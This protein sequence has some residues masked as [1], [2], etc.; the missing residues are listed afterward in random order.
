VTGEQ[1][2]SYLLEKE[3]ARKEVVT[4]EQ[5]HSYLLEKEDAR[6]EVVTGEQML[7]YL[8]EK[9]D[10]R[11][12]VVTGEQML[13]YLL[14]KED[15]R[16]EVVTGQEMLS[17]MLEKEPVVSGE[18]MLSYFL[19]VPSASPMPSPRSS[20]GL[21]T[22]FDLLEHL[23]FS[24]TTKEQMFVELVLSQLDKK[25]SG[26]DL[27]EALQS[28]NL[29][30]AGQKARLEEHLHKKNFQISGE[31]LYLYLQQNER[32]S[33]QGTGV[34][35]GIDTDS[36]DSFNGVV[37]LWDATPVDIDDCLS[38]MSKCD[39]EAGAE[40]LRAVTHSPSVN[41]LDKLAAYFCRSGQHRTLPICSTVTDM[42]HANDDGP[43]KRPVT[44]TQAPSK[45]F[46]AHLTP[47]SPF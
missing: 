12:E 10:A 14:E 27:L 36:S 26:A 28:K 20:E 3:D 46:L 35:G 41:L 19:N 16:Q 38:D 22:G 6:K 29:L 2:L 47:V 24:Q 37:D 4:G 8:L 45:S 9:E 13:S 31:M 34:E 11:K 43:S 1:L 30:E 7:S 44:A 32:I 5:M 15:A 40:I 21:E 33:M 18:D 39:P 25:I 42:D 17:Y 23:G